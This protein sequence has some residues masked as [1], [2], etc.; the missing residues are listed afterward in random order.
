MN[1][2]HLNISVDSDLNKKA[3]L[4]QINIS[5]LTEKAI[6]D[7][8]EIKQVEIQRGDKCEV[9]GRVDRQATREDMYGLNW[10][11]PEGIWIC[12]TCLTNRIEILK[13][14]KGAR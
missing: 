8:L 11:W 10:L 5:D 13:Q 14:K 7:K 6:R 4:A 3:K 12:N 2:T 1:K 9:C